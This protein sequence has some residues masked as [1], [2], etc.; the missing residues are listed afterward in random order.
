[1]KVLFATSEI[2]PFVKTGGLGDV[3]GALPLALKKQGVDVRLF[4]PGYPEI[5]KKISAKRQICKLPDFFGAN[6]AEIIF[7]QL[8][9]HLGA[10]V[11]VSSH[12]Y[13]RKGIYGYEAGKDWPD[14]YGRFGGFC[15][16]VKEIVERDPD[17]HPDI[18][19][20]NDWQC[21]LMPVYLKEMT[22]KNLPATIM[23]VHNM[24]YQGLFPRTLLPALKLSPA[25]FKADGIEF[26]NQ[27][28][29]LKAG[30]HYADFLTTVSP[31]YARE[32]QEPEM[33]CGLDGLLKYRQQ[34]LTGI[35]NGIDMETWDPANDPHLS[36]PY[37]FD[38]LD[39]KVRN[40]TALCDE[41]GLTVHPKKPVFSV[42]SR[43]VEQKGLDLLPSSIR[44]VLERGAGLVVLG[45][46][47]AALEEQFRT[48]EKE[49]PGQ[50]AVRMTYDESMAHRIM[51]GADAVI[52]P[53][54]FEPCG[55][56]Q[57]YGL[58]YGTLPIVRRTGGLA[59]SVTDDKKKA[60][61]FLFEDATPLS[62]ALALLQAYEMFRKPAQWKKMQ[63]RGMEK[64]FS[65]DRAAQKYVALYKKN[66]ASR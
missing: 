59:D 36:A 31:T 62:L 48:L 28:G 65:W 50:V 46:G 8:E 24:A 49:W 53:S 13:N 56:V 38:H 5:L 41:M 66:I 40:R 6:D 3:A 30:L 63:K 11:L 25:L 47:D 1:M 61:G 17:W 51:G 20:G 2:Y 57:M 29:F 39:Q 14:N 55:L 54:R 60:D 21:G 37:D 34:D 10:Y 23:T 27:I 44:A 22:Q 45:S 32:I 64:D 52:I 19:H 15:Y 12:F 18:V 35:L 4:L 58:R 43:L 9:N 16:A 7:G 42:I 33:G 26:Y